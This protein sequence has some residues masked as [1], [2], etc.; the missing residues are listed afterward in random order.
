MDVSF[1][2]SVMHAHQQTQAK[3]ES[4]PE[5]ATS[6]HSPHLSHLRREASA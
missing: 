2:K 4:T 1:V 3:D 5:H 6:M